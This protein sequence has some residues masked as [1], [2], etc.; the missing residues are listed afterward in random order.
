MIDA[1][2]GDVLVFSF[3]G[4]KPQEV[5]VGSRTAIDVAMESDVEALKE[6]VV[7]AGYYRDHG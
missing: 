7:N 3:I 5:E 6:V 2:P 4:Y 1:R